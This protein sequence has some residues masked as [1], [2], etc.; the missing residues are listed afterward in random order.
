MFL[1]EAEPFKVLQTE[2]LRK[3]VGDSLLEATPQRKGP[4][5]GWPVDHPSPP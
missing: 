2:G 5:E 4:P 1:E 3:Q